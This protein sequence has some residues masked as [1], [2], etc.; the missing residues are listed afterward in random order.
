VADGEEGELVITNLGRVGSPLIR[1]R[2]G[3]RVRV[4]PAARDGQ[5]FL[6]LEGG[7][8]GRVDDMV[9]IRGNNLYPSALEDVVRSV[10]GVAEFRIHL[11]D[12]LGLQRL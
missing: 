9:T 8:L 11:W 2:T 6:R 5:G 1:Y 7:I 10:P 4:A 12:G 3:D